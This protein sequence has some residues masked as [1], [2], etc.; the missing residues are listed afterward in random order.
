MTQYQPQSSRANFFNV[1]SEVASTPPLATSMANSTAA[2][3]KAL[4]TSGPAG[5][6]SPEGTQVR[7]SQ[8]GYLTSNLI[9]S[10]NLSTEV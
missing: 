1:K 5:R 3:G 8:E 9:T 2:P 10:Y 6:V 4:G 7:F